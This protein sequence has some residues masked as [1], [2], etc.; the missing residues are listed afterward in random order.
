MP[1]RAVGPLRSGARRGEMIGAATRPERG[2]LTMAL[3][4]DDDPRF[5]DYAHPERLVSTDWLARHLGADG[6]V[7]VESD[8]DVLLYET[9]HILGAVKVDWHLDLNDPVNRDYVD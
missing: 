4:Y 8:E 2:G 5:A 1:A 6:L 9:G 7:V 3:P